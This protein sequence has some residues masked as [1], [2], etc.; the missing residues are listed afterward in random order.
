MNGPVY[1]LCLSASKLEKFD[2]DNDFNSN[3]KVSLNSLAKY[4]TSMGE[5]LPIPL[6]DTTM[7]LSSKIYC[8]K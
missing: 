8:L 2:F 3:L 1:M 7:I 4:Q 6:T 5:L